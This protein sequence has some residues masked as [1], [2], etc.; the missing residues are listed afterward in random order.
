M[1]T[2][3][4]LGRRDLLGASSTVLGA[5]VIGGI[6]EWSRSARTATLQDVA[7]ENS[8][9]TTAPENSNSSMGPRDMSKWQISN[10]A[11]VGSPS[12]GWVYYTNAAFTA[13][14]FSRYAFDAFQD[15]MA[16]VAP[17]GQKFY[18]YGFTKTFNVPPPVVIYNLLKGAWSDYFSVR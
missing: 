5:A 18:Y 11:S 2:K 17:D 8:T 14:H 3:R 13:I 15:H 9:D 1:K 12:E 16:Y 7:A 4:M 10:A 6:F